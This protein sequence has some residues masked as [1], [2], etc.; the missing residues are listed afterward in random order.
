MYRRILLPT[1]GSTTTD[2]ALDHAADLASRYDAELHV[3]YVIDATVFSDDVATG[4]LQAEFEAQGESI[5]ERVSDR[6][7][8]AGV[9][10]VVDA[11]LRGTPHREILDYAADREIDLI[12]MGTHGRTGLDRYL[13]GSVTEKIVR[14]SDAPVLTVRQSDR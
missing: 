5:V 9:D 2:R 6:A 13:L 11:V 7:R 14:V 1:D 4:T 8:E 3:V 10:D 12:V